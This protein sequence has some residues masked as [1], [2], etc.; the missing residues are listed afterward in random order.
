MG[1]KKNAKSVPRLKDKLQENAYLIPEVQTH[2]KTLFIPAKKATKP[3][4]RSRGSVA[5]SFDPYKEWRWMGFLHH[6]HSKLVQANQ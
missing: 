4:K 3:G 5:L 1:V 6:G 2:P